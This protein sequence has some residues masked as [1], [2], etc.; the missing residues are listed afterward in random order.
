MADSTH[1]MKRNINC[2][3]CKGNSRCDWRTLGLFLSS[4]VVSNLSGLP[5]WPIYVCSHRKLHLSLWFREINHLIRTLWTTGKSLRGRWIQVNTGYDDDQKPLETPIR[6]RLGNDQRSI[7]YPC[8]PCV[9]GKC[10]EIPT[11]SLSVKQSAS[12]SVCSVLSVSVSSFVTLADK[13][14]SRARQ[15]EPSRPGINSPPH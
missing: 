8:F 3:V 14:S 7:A 10:S 9:S 6:A 1:I 11:Q 15:T 13:G 2:D 12:L 5:T 4:R